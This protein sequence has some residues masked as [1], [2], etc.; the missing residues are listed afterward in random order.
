MHKLE[1]DDLRLFISVN[2]CKIVPGSAFA[3]CQATKETIHLHIV[4]F[5]VDKDDLQKIRQERSYFD[6]EVCC[7]ACIL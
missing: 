3:S 5:F 6:T 7:V 1:S 2:P 4:Q